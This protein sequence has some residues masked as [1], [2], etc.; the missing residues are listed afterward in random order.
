[1]PGTKDRENRLTSFRE[2][3][4]A[5]A[6]LRVLPHDTQRPPTDA[7]ERGE[8]GGEDAVWQRWP[9]NPIRCSGDTPMGNRGQTGSTFWKSDPQGSL[10]S[11]HRPRGKAESGRIFVVAFHAP[12]AGRFDGTV[13]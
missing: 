5:S 4:R 6:R 11:G 1:M 9:N 2:T 10:Q 8:A 7:E 13:E 12:A 3:P